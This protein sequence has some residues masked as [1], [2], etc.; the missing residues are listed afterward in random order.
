MVEE[1]HRQS[2]SR[3]VGEY[4]H[5][6]TLIR[7][8]M[9]SSGALFHGLGD[10]A[11]KT[12]SSSAAEFFHLKP[13][14]SLL[15]ATTTAALLARGPLKVLEFARRIVRALVDTQQPHPGVT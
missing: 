2:E 13:T 14:A 1:G 3:K 8:S 11:L 15:L 7:E 12:P 9:S 4:L 5:D 6:S 10:H